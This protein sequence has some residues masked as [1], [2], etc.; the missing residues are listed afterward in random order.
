MDGLR[1]ATTATEETK[2][3]ACDGRGRNWG[4]EEE[5]ATPCNSPCLAVVVRL[6]VLHLRSG[7]SFFVLP[8]PLPTS[9]T[10]PRPQGGHGA[11]SGF[12]EAVV[13]PEVRGC[14][15][16]P[17]VGSSMTTRP[18]VVPWNVGGG[19]LGTSILRHHFVT[20]KRRPSP[21]SGGGGAPSP[22]SPPGDA[23][24]SARSGEGRCGGG[25]GGRHGG[26][27]S[28]GVEAAGRTS[29]PPDPAA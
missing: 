18:A 21:A 20:N 3:F 19:L 9:A 7:P 11:A 25:G 22:T 16:F 24:P 15:S 27:E 12:E 6:A 28:D 26:G 1:Q 14:T 23:L 17:L 2:D 10:P 13:D 5:V 8:S 4:R 29:P